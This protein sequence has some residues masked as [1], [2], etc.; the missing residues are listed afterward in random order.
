[1]TDFFLSSIVTRGDP[2]VVP[3]MVYYSRTVYVSFA[4]HPA[5]NKPGPTGSGTTGSVLRVPGEIRTHVSRDANTGVLPFDYRDHVAGV[6]YSTPAWPIVPEPVGSG[7]RVRI[8]R[9]AIAC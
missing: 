4:L 9:R 1:M 2:S 6:H 8:V 5:V 7:M 3:L